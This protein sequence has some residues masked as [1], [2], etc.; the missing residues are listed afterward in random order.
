[1]KTQTY[2]NFWLAL[3]LAFL[4]APLAA[5]AADPANQS[6]GP[7]SW[8][9]TSVPPTFSAQEAVK[10][11]SQYLG[12][13][14]TV[15]PA[16]SPQFV[17]VTDITSYGNVNK[18]VY[19]AWLVSLPGVPVTNANTRATAGV[20]MSVL[21]DAADKS[22]DAAFTAKNDLKWVPR[23]PSFK[24]RNPFQVM[25]DDGW[26]VDKPLSTQL[27]STVTQILSSFW[28]TTGISP[29]DAGQ[30]FLRPRYVALALPAKQ[31]GSR[32]LP[33]R[34]AGTYWTVRLNGTKTLDIV[35]PPPVSPSPATAD[36]GDTPYMSGLIAL[37]SDIGAQSVRG[38]YL[39]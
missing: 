26:S 28:R 20:D 1:M 34:P 9:A 29:A 39:P 12:V 15:K 16:T 5:M 36:G 24:A 17:Q 4:V 8:Q 10:Q 7:L 22:L 6:A 2:R 11:A 31:V 23:Y 13:S 19:Y 3:L 32:L 21:V 18:T 14:G 37:F 27:N 38:V 35:A 25:A 33:L 30:V